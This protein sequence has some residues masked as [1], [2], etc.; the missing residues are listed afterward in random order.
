MLQIRD[1]HG[2]AIESG[3]LGRASRFGDVAAGEQ[4]GTVVGRLLRQR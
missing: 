2:A 1:V 3:R 4:Q